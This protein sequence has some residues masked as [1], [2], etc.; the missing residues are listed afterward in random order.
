MIWRLEAVVHALK[1][2]LK[3]RSLTFRFLLLFAFLFAVN[4]SP[5]AA[6]DLQPTRL[7]LRADG[8]RSRSNGN[9]QSQVAW[10]QIITIKRKREQFGCATI[11]FRLT[12]APRRTAVHAYAGRCMPALVVA[13]VLSPL[14]SPFNTPCRIGS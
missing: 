5:A 13:V 2:Y 9:V 14:T 4:L 3:A 8:S 11:L 7:R 10:H 1:L 12:N 6:V